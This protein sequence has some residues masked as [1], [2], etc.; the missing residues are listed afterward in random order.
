MKKRIF[1]L[2]GLI[3]ICFLAKGEA[4]EKEIIKLGAPLVTEGSAWGK[5]FEQMNAELIKKSNGQL[6]FQFHFG[7]GD[8]KEMIAL[9]KNNQY[10]ALSLTT[11]GLGQ[12]L[13]EMNLLQ[14]PMLFST[15]DELYYVLDRITPKFSEPF[16]KKGFVFLGWA[17]YGFVYPFSKEPIKTQTD[18]QRTRF[19]AWDVD[20]IAKSFASA[21]GRDPILL[22]IQNV[23]PSLRNGDIQAIVSSPLACIALQWY[24]Q[25]KF[26][27]DL[28]ISVGMGATILD[29]KCFDRLS[30]EHKLLLREIT[31]KY[32][33]KLINTIREKNE[34]SIDVLKEQQIEVISVP[35]REKMKWIQVAQQVQNQFAGKL[36]RKEL[37]DE[38]RH[39]LETYRNKKITNS[40][41]R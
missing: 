24:T 16:E 2:I 1:Y 23:L 26:M 35:H 29:K 7:S 20:P 31:Q 32:H 18:L 38:V 6:L 14:L 17:A 39:L 21:S 34:E 19:W 33:Q 37:L 28:R 25:I 12:I 4:T 22:P 11:V 9:L 30:N 8:E 3:C 27:T 36:Y 5:N 41:S 15:Y 10:D 40:I 13:P